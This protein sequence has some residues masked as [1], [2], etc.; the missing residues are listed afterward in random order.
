MERKTSSLINFI[1]YRIYCTQDN[2]YN[3]VRIGLNNQAENI[4][5]SLCY[6]ADHQGKLIY[7]LTTKPPV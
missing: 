7:Y 1:I 5:L 2:N 4:Y 3:I 6:F